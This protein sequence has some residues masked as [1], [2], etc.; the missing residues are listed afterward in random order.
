MNSTP[1]A[2]SNRADAALTATLFAIDPVGLGGVALRSPPGPARD[3]WLEGLVRLLA[4]GA[5]MRR[6]PLHIDDSRL[7]GGLD[8]AASLNASRPVV[9]CG[10]LRELDGGVAILAM[11]ERLEAAGAARF[12]AVLDSGAVVLE[13][14]GLARRDPAR[15]GMV[16]L[17]EGAAPEER[18]PAAL[19][20]RM[21]FHLDLRS[22]GEPQ[23]PGDLYQP[24]D[25]NAARSRLAEASAPA[26][27]IMEALCAAAL[28][29]GIVSLRPPLLAL[30]AAR[31][32]AALRGGS[33][34]TSDDAVVA[35]RLVLAPRALAAPEMDSADP[36]T[37][38]DEPPRESSASD[39][40]SKTA[41]A[42]SDADMVV[43]A[44]LAALPEDFL[45]RVN[46]PKRDRK[47]ASGSVSGAGAAVSSTRCGRPRGSRSGQPQQGSR[48]NLVETL[49][50][51]APWQGL[52]SGAD[53]SVRMRV[54]RED[55]R[56]R[57]FVQRRQSTTIFVVDASGSTALQ[58]L[59]EAKGAVE[60]LLAKAYVTRANVALIGFRGARA[61]LLLPPTRSLTRAKNQLAELPG[62]GGTPLALGID[63]AV[64]LA[65]NEVA[66]G[67]TPFLVFLTDG[68]PNIGRD[69]APGRAAAEEDAMAAS[70]EVA[71][72]GISAAYLDTSPRAQPGG[73]RFA[74][75]MGAAYAPL[76]YV[77]AGAVVSLLSGLRATQAP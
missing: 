44:I 61:D 13:R 53:S 42:P 48:L 5:P 47:P 65:R 57:R 34:I 46:P 35:A 56:F 36:E 37:H 27:A 71:E 76:P 51:A 16:L 26:S 15:L 67:Q 41:D 58:R 69:G 55:F 17:D 62:G 30:R 66:K 9:Q 64:V 33:S 75:A 73:D 14:D 19:L 21:A 68:R 18:P 40:S 12:A 32:H 23:A 7:L 63:A 24:A 45:T 52:R 54:R 38:Q 77:D 28:M 4:P 59:A 6:V 1:D 10:L 43:K 22:D 29:M 31:A 8:L 25:V 49:R 74:L 39:D 20:E 2:I 50:A 60:L 3:A 11:A 70:R 72:A